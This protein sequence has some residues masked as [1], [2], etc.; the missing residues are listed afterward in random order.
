MNINIL[1]IQSKTI[2]NNKIDF[3]DMIFDNIKVSKVQRKLGNS[4][5]H[6]KGKNREEDHVSKVH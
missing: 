3:I 5:E 6:K 4:D 1:Y 2:K